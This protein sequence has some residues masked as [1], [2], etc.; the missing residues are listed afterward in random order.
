MKPKIMNSEI[1]T[2]Q[3]RYSPDKGWEVFSPHLQEWVGMERMRCQQGCDCYLCK[4]YPTGWMGDM[5]SRTL[6]DEEITN[7]RLALLLQEKAQ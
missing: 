1:L 2:W 6:S 5:P 4:G 7:Q 3:R